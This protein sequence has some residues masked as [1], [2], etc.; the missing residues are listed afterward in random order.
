MTGLLLGLLALDP[1]TLWTALDDTAGWEEVD[2]KSYSDLGI[3]VLVRHKVVSGQHCL[4]GSTAAALPVA[5]LIALASDI[6][7]QPSWSRYDLA[8]AVKLSAGADR[9]DYYEVLDNPSPVADRAWFVRGEVLRQ[10]DTAIFRWNQ[11]D[12][13]ALYPDQVAAVKAEHSGVVFTRVNAGDWTFTPEG[14]LTRIR[15]R[16]CTDAG[17]DLPAS[18][19]QY[20]ATKTLPGN[21][22]DIVQEAR[23]QEK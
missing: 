1:T 15:Y 13:D 23:R 4:E 11:I 12:A 21:L 18:I 17:G 8:A 2:R 20:A 19:G 6:P 16:I 22:A 9:F 10:G 14:A 3:E 5:R 7:N